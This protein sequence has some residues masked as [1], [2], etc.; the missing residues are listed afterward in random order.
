MKSATILIVD[1]EPINVQLLEVHLSLAGYQVRSA[2]NGREALR[3]IAQSRPDLVILD[4]MMPEMDGFEVCDILR[5]QPE[6]KDLPI[7]LLTAL[8][9]S[10]AKQHGLALGASD[11]LTKPIQSWELLAR[12]R[13]HL[14]LVELSAQF[15]YQHQQGHV[16]PAL[17]SLHPTES[18]YAPWVFYYETN[19]AD[20][21]ILQRTLQDLRYDAMLLH[22]L[23]SNFEHLPDLLMLDLDHQTSEV[24]NICHTLK[25]RYGA[26]LP[27]VLM[28]ASSDRNSKLQAWEAGVDEYLRKPIDETELLVRSRALL[29]R[30]DLHWQLTQTVD[31]MS[32]RA[33]ID[34]LTQLLNRGAF[35]RN[36]QRE[37]ERVKSCEGQVALIMADVDHFKHYNDRN[38]HVAG[39]GIL[40]QVGALLSEESRKRDIVARYGGEEFAIILPDTSEDDARMVAQ[41]IQQRFASVAFP[42][43]HAQPLGRLSLSMGIAALPNDHINSPKEL[44]ESADKALYEAKTRGRNR[45]VGFSEIDF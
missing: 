42:E 38:G 2:H 11:F 14:H 13:S 24:L 40:K 37:F 30:R 4:V 3:M 7:I 20:A 28:S 33:T 18:R 17:G 29:K 15:Q 8:D 5:K 10:D 25:E 32:N 36:L 1:D 41:R 6:T 27:I 35:D 19:P 39:D 23:P 12:M 43:G 16:P 31:E 34:A 26:Q 21:D 45:A 44:I 9:G 22:E